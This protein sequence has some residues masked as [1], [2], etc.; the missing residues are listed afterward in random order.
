MIDEILIGAMRFFISGIS[1][2]FEP[3]SG[4][5]GLAF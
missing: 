1:A 4:F 3:S 5:P 2:F